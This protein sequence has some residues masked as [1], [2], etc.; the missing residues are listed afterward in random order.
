MPRMILRACRQPARRPA[1]WSEPMSKYSVTRTMGYS[2]RQLF[3][4]AADVDNYRKFLPLVKTS[5]TFDVQLGEDGRKRFKGELLIQYIKLG[6]RERFIS[7]VSVDPVRLTVNSH[8]AQ[9][10]VELLDSTWRFID[11][12][13][14]T[15]DV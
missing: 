2:A 4:I 8:S 6:I 9:G 12:P 7:Q 3:D 13:D 10:P 14:G 15:C 1:G 11:R 5:R